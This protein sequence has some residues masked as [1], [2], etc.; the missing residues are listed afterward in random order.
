MK[1][2]KIRDQL[3]KIIK[4]QNAQIDI[5]NQHTHLLDLLEHRV[6]QL[7][8]GVGT[9]THVVVS[10]DGKIGILNIHGFM[11]EEKAVEWRDQKRSEGVEVELSILPLQIVPVEEEQPEP[12]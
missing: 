11:S 2:R 1:K 3:Q 8:D 4:A 7:N 9:P 12:V 10:H 6:S 5:V